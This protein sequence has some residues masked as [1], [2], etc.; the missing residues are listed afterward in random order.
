MKI[1]RK[2]DWLWLF[3]FPVY[4]LIGTLRH[5]AAHAAVAYL[6][7][8]EIIKLTFWPSIYNQKFYFGYVI[9]RGETDW[10]TIAA[11]YFLD[12]ITCGLVFPWVFFV[13][14]RKRW[15][16][17]NLVI[18]GLISPLVNS[19]Y[20]YLRGSDVRYL[21]E[22]LPDLPVHVCFLS[23]MRLGALGLIKVFTTSK[24][25]KLSQTESNK[26]S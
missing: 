12:I 14:F 9:W 6:Q 15:L 24:Q 26:F 5:E 22:V 2:R 21:Y 23:G 10:L 1:L 4:L 20:N 8:A 19:L 11:P 7:G 3:L 17:L 13:H 25:A 18:I 16:W